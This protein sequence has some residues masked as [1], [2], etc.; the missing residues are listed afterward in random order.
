MSKIRIPK[1]HLRASFLPESFDSEKRTVEVVWTTGAKVKRFSWSEGMYFEEL[2]LQKSHVD[3]SRLEAGAPVLNNHNN[4]DLRDQ[5]GVVEKAWIKNKEGRAI[6][7]F[8]DRE[9]VQGIVRDIENGIIKNISVGYRVNKFEDVTKKGEETPTLRATD[10]T[11]MEISFVNIPADQAAQV[12]SEENKEDSYEC[13]ILNKRE[14][15][16]HQN[17]ETPVVEN[18][19]PEVP[20]TD[21]T[22]TEPEVEPTVETETVEETPSVDEDAIRA[23]GA[24]LEMTRQNEIREAVRGAGLELSFGQDLI[25]NKVLVSDARKLIIEELAKRNEQNATNGNNTEVTGM[26]QRELRLQDAESAILNRFKPESHELNDGARIFRNGTLIDMAREFLTS[27]GLDCRGLSPNEIAGIALNDNTRAHHTTDFP[28]LLANVANKVLRDSYGERPQTF[29]PFV[30]ERTVSDFKEITNIQ[31][32]DAPSLEKI[33]EHGEFTEGTI[34]ESAEKYK[35]ETYGRIFSMT[36]QLMVNDDLSAFTKMPEKFGRRSRDLESDIVWGIITSNALMADGKGVFHAD[37]ANLGTASSI[38]IAS[39]GEA[40]KLMRAQLGL[41]KAKL[42]LRASYL[43][44][45]SALETVAE[46]FLGPISATKDSDVN[47]FKNKLKIISEIRLDDASSTAW[48]L[49]ADKPQLD[50]VEIARLRGEEAPVLTTKTGF[51]VDGMK[52]KVKYDFAAKALDYRGFVRNV[53][54]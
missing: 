24:E 50:M 48:Y 20:A 38:D 44:V 5:F 31:H 21:E 45:P 30:S 2:S 41:D 11:P 10:W 26:D 8:S 49:F 42:D 14:S 4:Y 53:G 13:E 27:E 33:N 47:P 17:E 29:S 3:L 16:M 40:R 15:N 22:R 9:E 54:A 19:L 12:R 36:R 35:L 18:E 28:Q 52:I 34:S 6:L 23:E 46:Q 25:G 1:T 51:E 39:V 37:H 7:R 43:V 32:G